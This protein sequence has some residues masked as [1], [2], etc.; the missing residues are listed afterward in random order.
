MA[1]GAFTVSL[2]LCTT[3][4]STQ[5]RAIVS[6]NDWDGGDLTDVTS[7]H[8]FG[9]TRSS[10]SQAGWTVALSPDGAWVWN[11]GDGEGR[12]D[13]RPPA[14]GGIVADGNW[15]MLAFSIDPDAAQARLYRDGVNVATYS[16][17]DLGDVRSGAD[18]VAATRIGDSDVQIEDLRIEPGV[19]DGAQIR[20]R[21]QDR[22]GHRVDEGL[23]PEP[24][25]SLRVMAWNIWHGGRRDGDEAG[26]QATI[27]A[28]RTS[29]ADVVAMQETYGS[30]AHIA[31]GLGYHFY[32]RSSNLSIMSRYPIRQ[33]HALYEPFRFGGVTIE[34][35]PGQLL[36][37][38][39]LWIH[40]LPDYGGRMKDLDTPVSV[41]LLLEEEMQTRGREI[42]EILALLEAHINAST[43]IPLIVAGDF[44]SPSDL[45]WGHDTTDRH[46]DLVVPWPV[47]QSMARA[48]F[49]DAFRVV[50]PDPVA[51]PG[52]T[53]SPKSDRAWKD[54][55]DY[56]Y[57]HGP[58]L[59]ARSASVRGFGESTW[60][61]DHAAVI[62]DVD[63]K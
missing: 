2:W 53:W 6:D 54:R 30:G 26:L 47:S 4:T 21:W 59:A 12:L 1:S 44:N 9:M 11:V 55:I 35:S 37:L 48:G 33:T 24:V 63:I 20:Q 14:D 39:S 17:S 31:A 8:D 43:R 16:L 40:Y 32:L 36:N 27:D 7:H 51:E 5:L 18:A 42:E 28:I 3:A 19:V 29:G 46:R 58:L 45:D 61:S 41:A 56:V 62:V 52:Y 50:H 34:L 57:L 10:G 38:F 60:T 25:T 22:A 15:H 13:Y 23:S 49:V